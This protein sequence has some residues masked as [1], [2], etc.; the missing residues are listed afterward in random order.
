MAVIVGLLPPGCAKRSCSPGR[1]SVVVMTSVLESAVRDVAGNRIAVCRILPPGSCP[2]H[3]D[4]K[5]QD[6]EAIASSPLVFRHDYETHLDRKL[7]DAGAKAKRIVAVPTPGSQIIPAN[8]AET[9]RIICQELSTLLPQH[10]AEF[11]ARLAAIRNH[12]QTLSQEMQTTLAPLKGRPV[13]ASQHQRGFAEWCGLHVVGTFDTSGGMSLKE[14]GKIIAKAKAQKVVAVI[15][16]RQRGTREA[17]ALAAK[18]SVPVVVLSNFP[19][20][21][22]GQRTLADLIRDNCRKLLAGVPHG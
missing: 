12:M 11:D 8:Y 7:K 13:L 5:P 14:L 2:G 1:P 22:Q 6:F 20:P 17:D 4:L 10:A 18:L 16:N 9:C 21:E 15:A 19:D 3:F